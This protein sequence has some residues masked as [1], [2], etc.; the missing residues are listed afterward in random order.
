MNMIKYKFLFY[1][2]DASHVHGLLI[3]GSYKYIQ[4]ENWF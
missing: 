2:L 3:I 4:L 1:C